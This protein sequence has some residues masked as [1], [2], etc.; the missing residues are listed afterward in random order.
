MI[1]SLSVLICL[2]LGCGPH[3]EDDIEF[4]IRNESNEIIL[5]DSYYNGINRATLTEILQGA[6]SFAAGGGILDGD[7]VLFIRKVSNDSIMYRNARHGDDISPEII[8][9][10]LK[11]GYMKGIISISIVSGMKILSKV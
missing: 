8:S 11:T 7:S 9:T 6:T 5:M 2:L 3:N 1:R 10:I 4:R